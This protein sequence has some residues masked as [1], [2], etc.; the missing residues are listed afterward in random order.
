VDADPHPS[1][2]ADQRTE[3]AVTEK[4]LRSDHG[5]GSSLSMVLL[6]PLFFILSMMAFQSAMWSHAR[7]EARVRVRDMAGLI[8]RSGL[9]T[10]QA[11]IQVRAAMNSD[12]LLREI[13]LE[14]D[15]Q[16][17][18]VR[19]GLRAVAPGILRGTSAPVEVSTTL[20]REGWQP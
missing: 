1:Q 10:E 15:D 4:Y 13:H 14:V 11:E 8:A 7:T 3:R 20:W 6:A 16:G 18:T 17:A 9:T 19:V 12:S 2:Y 5:A